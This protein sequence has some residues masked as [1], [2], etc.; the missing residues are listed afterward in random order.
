MVHV[1]GTQDR[2]KR[3]YQMTDRDF[4]LSSVTP[5]DSNHLAKA[6]ANPIHCRAI[7]LARSMTISMG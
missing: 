7:A 4:M 1:F 6:S 5:L 3:R 2:S